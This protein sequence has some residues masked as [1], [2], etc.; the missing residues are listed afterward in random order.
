M[1]CTKCG[2]T[3]NKSCFDST[4]DKDRNIRRQCKKCRL[5]VFRHW[6]RLPSVRF[7]TAKAKA[8]S[9]TKGWSLSRK[10]YFRLIS[11][12]CHYCGGKLPQVAI[13]L[14]RVYNDKGYHRNN[15][16][17]CCTACN[18]MRNGYITYSQ[19]IEI[20]SFLIKWRKKREK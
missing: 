8:K 2:R 14:D 19:M 4:S 3:K 15:V 7:N 6:A 11:K 10:E 18:Y 20:K 12:S 16:V 1:R 9:R 17:P 5:Q 13:G